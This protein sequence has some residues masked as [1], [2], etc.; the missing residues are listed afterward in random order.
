[1]AASNNSVFGSGSWTTVVVVGTKVVDVLAT[2]LVVGTDTDG[3]IVELI[4]NEIESSNK[5]LSV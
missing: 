3:T 2:G 1:M 5:S 4:G